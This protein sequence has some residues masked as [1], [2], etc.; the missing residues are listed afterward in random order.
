MTILVDHNLEGQAIV[1]WGTLA[2]EGWLEVLSLDIVTLSQV[3]LPTDSSD[4]EVWH[5]AQNH[6]MILLTGNR[7]MKGVDSLEQIIREEGRALSLPVITIGSVD[8][9]DEYGYR[10]RCSVRLV[11]L[12]LDIDAYRGTG[13]M[14]IP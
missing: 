4:R 6:Q 10:E 8:R 14:Y 5:F 1:L 7:R 9:L 13:R 11:E 3:G 2:A 12:L